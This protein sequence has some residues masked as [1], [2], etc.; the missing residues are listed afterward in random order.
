MPSWF[1][2]AVLGYGIG[3]AAT[4][5]LYCWNYRDARNTFKPFKTYRYEYQTGKFMTC[6]RVGPEVSSGPSTVDLAVGIGKLLVWPLFV[7]EEIIVRKGLHTGQFVKLGKD[8]ELEEEMK[9]SN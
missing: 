8:E 1:D 5:S 3:A 7:H 6:Y 4:I 2:L 9:K